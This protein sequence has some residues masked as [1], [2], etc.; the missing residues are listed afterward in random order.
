MAV[1]RPRSRLDIVRIIVFAAIVLG[2]IC[3]LIAGARTAG[4]V[5]IL[6]AVIG[7]FFLWR[8]HPSLRS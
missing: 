8:V 3:T 7:A 6:V 5:L 2:I 4:G 1:T